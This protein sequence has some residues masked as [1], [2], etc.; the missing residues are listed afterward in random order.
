MVKIRLRRAGKKNA[1][2]YRLVVVDARV[3]RDGGYI[4]KLGFY[5]P[6]QGEEAVN[7]DRVDYWLGV[8]AQ[9]TGT[10]ADLIR[11]ARTGEA[12]AGRKNI[13]L[14]KEEAPAEEAAAEEAE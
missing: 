12:T 6:V 5:N 8:G 11:R 1:P 13:P 2:C 4:E 7:I 3:K 14:P 10:A 9:A